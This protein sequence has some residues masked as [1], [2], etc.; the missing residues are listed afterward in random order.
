MRR[1]FD[2][3]RPL[4]IALPNNREVT[5]KKLFILMLMAMIIAL[6]GA[7]FAEALD[8]NIQANVP[9]TCRL[10]SNVA[11]T[12]SFPGLTFNAD[13]TLAASTVVDNSSIQYWC[14]KGL[15]PTSLDA[16]SNVFTAGTTGSIGDTMTDGTDTIAYNYSFSDPGRAAGDGPSIKTSITV[17]ADIIDGTA[18]SGAAGT[19]TDTIVLT[20]TP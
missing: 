6:A 13:G 11:V 19:Y 15:V 2:N 14:T 4:C 20:L 9:G 8:V 7:Q 10:T 12:V 16:D 17:Q 18:F 1:H 3:K 5:M